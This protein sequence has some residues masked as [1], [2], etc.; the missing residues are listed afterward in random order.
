MLLFWRHGYRGVSIRDISVETGALPG[1]LHYRYGGKRA[2]YLEAIRHYVHEH[3]EAPLAELARR[4][5]PRNAIVN[6]FETAIGSSRDGAVPKGCLVVN[7]ALE[8]AA[9]DN[10]VSEIVGQVF[11]LFQD[12]LR[13]LIERGQAKG[14]IQGL[15]DPAET[16]HAL[17]TMYVG[18]RVLSRST[19]DEALLRQ[20][21]RSVDAILSGQS[22]SPPGP[23]GI[24]QPH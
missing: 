20:I 21:V 4:P 15:L 22:G 11:N 18:L 8:L 17:R 1:S 7:A 14:E 10:D 16:S 24:I 9:D 3:C 6:F 13:N 23:D 19:S 5:S 12:S 2:L